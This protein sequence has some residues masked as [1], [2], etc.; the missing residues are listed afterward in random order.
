MDKSRQVYGDFHTGNHGMK[1]G[2]PGLYRSQKSAHNYAVCLQM[3]YGWGGNDKRKQKCFSR[4]SVK[5]G[6][7]DRPI[8][9]SSTFKAGGWHYRQANARC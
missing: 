7:T 1:C 3:V 6:R 2:T 4:V 8:A 9:L 5:I